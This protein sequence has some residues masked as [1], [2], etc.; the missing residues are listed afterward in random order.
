MSAT[1]KLPAS[2]TT[3]IPTAPI[4]HDPQITFLRPIRSDR[5]AAGTIVMSVPDAAAP[6]MIGTEPPAASCSIASDRTR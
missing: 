2:A 3:V 5:R 4:T 1:G 6:A